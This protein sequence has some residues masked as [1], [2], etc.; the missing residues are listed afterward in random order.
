MATMTKIWEK[1]TR[2]SARK[3]FA[4]AKRRELVLVAGRAWRHVRPLA[5]AEVADLEA[6]GVRVPRSMRP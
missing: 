5:P 4:N 1:R 2:I 6:R 3:R